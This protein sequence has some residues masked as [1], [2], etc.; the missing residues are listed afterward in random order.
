[1][2]IIHFSGVYTKEQALAELREKKPNHQLCITSQRVMDEYLHFKSSTESNM[3]ANPAILQMK[4]ARIV[5]LFVE[6]AGLSYEDAL[7]KFYDSTTYDLISNGAADMHCFSD[8]KLYIL[9]GG[10]TYDAAGRLV[11]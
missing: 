5:K 8:G 10:K 6:Q 7:G 2:F 11:K 4:Y 1:M 9:R 3:Q